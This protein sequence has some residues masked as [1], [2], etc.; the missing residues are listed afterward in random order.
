ML[1]LNDSHRLGDPAYAK[2]LSGTLVYLYSAKEYSR[3]IAALH[4]TQTQR[5]VLRLANNG[6]QAFIFKMP[7]LHYTFLN[8]QRSIQCRQPSLAN[9]NCHN[10][11]R[12][13][14]HLLRGPTLESST[15]H[16]SGRRKPLA[17]IPFPH[18]AFEV[19]Q[20]ETKNIAIAPYCCQ[21]G[22]QK[23]FPSAV[24][25]RFLQPGSPERGRRSNEPEFRLQCHIL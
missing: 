19:R 9:T 24:Q 7:L 18:S 4:S 17:T 8:C 6:P 15:H 1:Y 16:N 22:F 20:V 25:G 3:T 13:P 10:G 14:S 21:R 5:K 11:Q 2:P 23:H 12:L